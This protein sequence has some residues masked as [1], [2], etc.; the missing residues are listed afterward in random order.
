MS[1]HLIS[2]FDGSIRRSGWVRFL[3]LGLLI[4]VLSGCS[5]TVPKDIEVVRPFDVQRYLGQWYE[6]ARLDHSFERNMNQV[7]ATYSLNDDGSIKVINRGFDTQRQRWNEAVGRAEF[8]LGPDQGALRVSFFGPFYGGYFIT[9][10]DQVNYQWA[11]VVGPD[12]KYFW[13]LSREK[14]LTSDVKEKLLAQA[15]AM[16]IVLDEIIWVEQ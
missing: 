1:A 10:L 15:E 13:I 8:V 16:G 3:V 14:S 2:T 5:V 11:M 9:A 4:L 7:S 6:I 12:L